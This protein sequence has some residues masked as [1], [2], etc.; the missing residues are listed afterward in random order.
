ME[1]QC[2][3][4]ESGLA[5]AWLQRCEGLCGLI[6]PSLL[7]SPAVEPGPGGECGPLRRRG[8]TRASGL[9]RGG[10]AV[11]ALRIWTV[12]MHGIMA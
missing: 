4:C 10:S 9:R 8:L 1:G 7:L 2:M 6:P 12:W 5:R 3:S 11:H